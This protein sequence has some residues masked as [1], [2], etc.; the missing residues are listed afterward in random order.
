M[1]FETDDKVYEKKR[2]VA[3][4][5]IRQKEKGAI[6][7]YQKTLQCTKGVVKGEN[8]GTRA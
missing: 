8:R 1:E 2:Q 7:N 5:R 6:G 4:Q 3:A